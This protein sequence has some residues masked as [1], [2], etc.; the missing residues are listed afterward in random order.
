MSIIWF[1]IATLISVDASIDIFCLI[2]QDE[3]ASQTSKLLNGFFFFL[4]KRAQ[5]QFDHFIT[6]QSIT[7]VYDIVQYFILELSDICF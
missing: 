4:I 7:G 3:N 6:E 2:I 1:K 5:R